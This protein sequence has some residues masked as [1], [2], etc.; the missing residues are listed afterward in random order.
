MK[1]FKLFTTFTI[2]L[3]CI[4][5]VSCDK[6]DD[7]DDVNA[8]YSQSITGAWY[9]EE[10]E[11]GFYFDGSGNGIH[12]YD[13]YEDEFTYKLSGNK[14]MITEEGETYTVTIK[15]TGNTLKITEDGDTVT[16]KKID[17]DDIE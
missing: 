9:S 2:I 7:D 16:Y 8:K 12:F 5:I 14:L 1:A 3:M 10:E 4:G 6:D 11:E 13:D 15:I 17:I